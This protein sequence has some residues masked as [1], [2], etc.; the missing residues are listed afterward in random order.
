[1]QPFHL[2][3]G[4]LDEARRRFPAAPTPWI[5]LS[6]GINPEPYLGPRASLAARM[7]LPG[8]GETAALEAVAAGAFGL[9]P[10]AVLAAPGAEAAIRLLAASIPA[11]RV[12]VVRPTYSG[13]AEA[14]RLA[15]AEV[16][17]VARDALAEAADGLDALVVVNPNNPDGATTAPE[18][19]VDLARRLAARDGWLMV[20]EAFVEVAPDLS[21]AGAMG[22]A[23]SAPNLVALRSFGK[24][25]GL[26]GV[27]LGF[28]AG[29]PD[30]IARLR[31]RQG[32]WPVSADAIAAGRA[33]YDDAA[34]TAATRVRLAEDARRLD[35][36]LVRAGF[37]VAGGCDLF[38]LAEADDAP[39]RF[40]RL[41]EAGILTR[42]FDYAPRWLRFG[43][44]AHEHWPRLEAALM[45]SAR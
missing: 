9:D 41:A 31:R 11:R 25:Y 3:G 30:L 22:E 8:P 5:D 38:R 18:R 14:W 21:V 12:G 16:I 13:H 44:P 26:P 27:R 24:F 23:W 28:V 10:A 39:A 15:G 42:P 32:D 37:A 40:N 7:R 45:E 19:L 34:W 6:T 35:G 4:R 2:H 17:D 36:L 29:D 1:M 33:A 20:D 43:L